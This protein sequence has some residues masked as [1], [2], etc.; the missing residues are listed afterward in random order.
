MAGETI[1]LDL[2]SARVF[3]AL[4]PVTNGEDFSVT[5]NVFDGGVPA[6]LD[7]KAIAVSVSHPAGAEAFALAGVLSDDA[8]GVTSVVT[9][10]AR[11]AT[12][13]TLPPG[14]YTVAA[15]LTDGT[16]TRQVLLARLPVRDGGFG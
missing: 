14:S 16:A 12:M 1:N 15:R 10:T 4:R 2:T 6:D 13:A 8:D 5:L 3:T 11:A 9:F 7:G